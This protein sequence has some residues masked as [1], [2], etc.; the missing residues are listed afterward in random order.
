M[1][2]KDLL[3][4]LIEMEERGLDMDLPIMARLYSKVKDG[5]KR[6]GFRHEEVMGTIEYACNGETSFKDSGEHGELRGTYLGT[7]RY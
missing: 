2:R 7:A 3:N 6:G 1:T 4:R 5:R